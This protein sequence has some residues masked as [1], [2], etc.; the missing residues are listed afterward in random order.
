MSGATSSAC[1]GPGDAILTSTTSDN[2]TC[3]SSD[4]V[5]NRRS[6]HRCRAGGSP[7]RRLIGYR[8]LNPLDVHLWHRRQ[9]SR[10][11]QAR[12]SAQIGVDPCTNFAHT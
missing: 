5:G 7:Q 12:D 9:L 3:I 10:G 6:D 4:G 11:Q 1:A 2:A 8:Q